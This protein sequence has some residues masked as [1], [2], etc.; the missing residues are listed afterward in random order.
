MAETRTYDGGCHCGAVRYRVT[1]PL[2]SA[3]VCNCSICSRAGTVLAPAPA[4]QF[5]L[6]SGQDDLRDYQFGKKVIHHLFCGRCGIK[7]F[8]RG[9]ARDGSDMV[10]VN[11]RCLDGV[12]LAAIP[13]KPFDGKSLPLD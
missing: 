5:E 11:V 8:A 12:D 6:L 13:V 10:A 2:E 9:K 1:L 7:S 4:A 3:F